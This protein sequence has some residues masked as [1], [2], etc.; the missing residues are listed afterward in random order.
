MYQSAKRIGIANFFEY[1]EAKLNGKA[2][3]RCVRGYL[4]FTGKLDIH[5]ER[6]NEFTISWTLRFTDIRDIWFAQ[7]GLWKPNLLFRSPKDETGEIGD[8]YR[9]A[10]YL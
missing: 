3:E 4:L 10:A 2:F 5:H 9:D 1:L 7:W 6:Y 8:G